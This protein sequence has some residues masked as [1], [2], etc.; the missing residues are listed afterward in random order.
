MLG[1]I[2]M[3]DNLKKEFKWYLDNQ[4]DLVK[5][6][7]GKIIVIKDCEVIGTFDEIGTAVEETSKTYDMGTFLVQKCSSGEED[8][9]AVFHSRV[10]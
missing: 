2:A 8:Y 1:E 3:E 7:N 10:A 6:Y 5:K 4:N 9:T